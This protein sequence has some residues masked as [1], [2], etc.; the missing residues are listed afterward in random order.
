MVRGSAT[1]GERAAAEWGAARLRELGA[2]DV[3]LQEFRYQRSWAFR[4]VPHFAAGV[5]AGA[6]GGAG[7]ALLG[8]A[9][10]ASYELDFGGRLQWLAEVAPR[11]E[12][13]NVAA[14]LPAAGT[15]RRTL[16]LV[17][18]ID[19][20]QTGLSWRIVERNAQTRARG[21]PGWTVHP[22]VMTSAGSTPKAAF[23]LLVAGCATGLR[24]PRLVGTAALAGSAALALETAAND[25]VPGAS[26]NASGVAGVLALAERFA[27]EPLPETE[28]IVLLPG[29]E[30]SGMGGMREWLQTSGAAL[31]RGRTLVLGLDTLGAGEPVV[32]REEGPFRP[33][34]Y[35]P[36]DLDRADRG[37]ARAGLPRP[38]R[39]R[40]GAWTDPILAVHAG[41]PA[42]SILSVRGSGFTNYHLPTDTPDRVDWDSVDACV[43]LAAGVAEDFAA[44]G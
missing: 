43:R 16:V 36:E 19:A 22:D 44:G 11:G 33:E 18:H 12:G 25:P 5:L 29:C 26:D 27:A 9:A 32:V 28:V 38:R 2:S 20:A 31:D 34:A 21:F 14:R 4:H 35:R 37:A 13:T 7:G 39:M 17:A 8:L 30:E 3:A 40:L 10:A 15:P 1:P 23:A 6:W 24:L 42:V 41:L